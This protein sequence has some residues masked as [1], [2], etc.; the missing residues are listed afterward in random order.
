M[1]KLARDLRLGDAVYDDSRGAVLHVMALA[2][3]DTGHILVH[4][5]D[6]LYLLVVTKYAPSE[7]VLVLE[8]ERR[9]PL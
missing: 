2:L 1:E 4:Y 3:G 5:H 7:R 9:R 8:L 6:D